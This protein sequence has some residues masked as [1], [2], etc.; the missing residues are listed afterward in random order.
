M[1]VYIDGL[2]NQQTKLGNARE[3]LPVTASNYQRRPAA[4]VRTPFA[5]W[6]TALA[7]GREI[8]ATIWQVRVVEVVGWKWQVEIWVKIHHRDL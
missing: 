1:Y 7:S 2:I 6:V 8:D 5:L 4:A 3:P